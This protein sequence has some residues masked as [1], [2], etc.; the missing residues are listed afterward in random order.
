MFL[1]SPRVGII[2]DSLYRA[3][4]PP[5]ATASHLVD[6][7]RSNTSTPSLYISVRGPNAAV[8][9]G[10]KRRDV[11]KPVQ[12]GMDHEKGR[13]AHLA[14]DVDMG[15]ISRDTRS[16]ADIVEAEGRNEWVGLQ[17]QGE[18]LADTACCNGISHQR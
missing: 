17:E 14:D 2:I 8:T 6:G 13:G 18:R 9:C 12:R 16:T 5:N 3:I 15:N 7:T 1:E 10:E 4:L 11:G